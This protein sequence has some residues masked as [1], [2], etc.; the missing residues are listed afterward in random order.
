[1]H[2]IPVIF[3]ILIDNINMPFEERNLKKA[4]GKK[5]LDYKRKVRR[6]I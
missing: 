5:Y 1:L 2:F 6:W 3:A 4:F